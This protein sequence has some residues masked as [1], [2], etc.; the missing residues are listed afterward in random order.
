MK[1]LFRPF[2]DAVHNQLEGM[3]FYRADRSRSTKIRRY[4]QVDLTREFQIRTEQRE[5]EKQRRLEELYESHD[6]RASKI[7]AVTA[8]SQQN[9]AG[10]SDLSEGEGMTTDG[11]DGQNKRKLAQEA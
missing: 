1:R 6:A 8:M 5:K 2:M 7:R 10:Q 3:K 4:E 9:Q 11:E